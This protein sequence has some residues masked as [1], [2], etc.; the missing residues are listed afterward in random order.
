VKK[1]GRYRVTTSDAHAWPEAWFEGAGWVRFEPTPRRD[2][3]TSV[4]AYAAVAAAGPGSP[5]APG[6]EPAP[7]RA[8]QSTAVDRLDEKLARDNG[9]P[10]PA[11]PK[12]AAGAA[13]HRTWIALGVV[14]LAAVLLLPRLLYLLRRRQRWRTGDP[15]AGWAQVCEDATDLGHLWRPSDSPRAAAA[16]LSQRYELDATARSALTRLATAAERAR[17]ARNGAGNVDGLAGDAAV[18]RAA[19][20]AAVGRKTRW[21]AWLLPVST[22]GWAASVSGTLVADGLDRV[23]TLWSSVRRVLRIRAA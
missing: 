1:D 23:D 19:V 9:A 13:S 21:R 17:Y 5:E 15:L 6:A 7:S 8:P 10:A 3:Q 14:A 20:A 11:T 12:T 4:P 18:V 22:L 16:A 2:G